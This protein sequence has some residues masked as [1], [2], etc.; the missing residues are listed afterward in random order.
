[1]HSHR[2]FRITKKQW[3][4]QQ[5]VEK[6]PIMGIS[7]TSNGYYAIKNKKADFYHILLK[8]GRKL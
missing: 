6:R 8:K 2:D 5:Q 1:V 7:F 3:F 4:S